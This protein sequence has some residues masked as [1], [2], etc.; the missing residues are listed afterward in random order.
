MSIFDDLLNPKPRVN[1]ATVHPDL[2]VAFSIWADK[3]PFFKKL[4]ADLDQAIKLKAFDFK[5]LMEC[6]YKAG[7]ERSKL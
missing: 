1:K 5:R 4:P 6:A 7:Y 3:Q 2:S